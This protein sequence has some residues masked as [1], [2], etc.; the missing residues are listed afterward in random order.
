MSEEHTKDKDEASYGES[1]NFFICDT[2]SEIIFRTRIMY[3]RIKFLY[4]QPC[5]IDVSKV[6]GSVL[7]C[8]GVKCC[9]RHF[10]MYALLVLLNSCAL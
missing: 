5:N 6:T 10:L 1:N 8:I 3:L 9:V 4:W 2:Y 7:Y